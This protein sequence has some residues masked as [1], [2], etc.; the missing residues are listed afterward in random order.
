MGGSSSTTG[1]SRGTSLYDAGFTRSGVAAGS[2]AAKVHS[3]IGNVSKGSAFS[4]AQSRGA[5]GEG[6]SCRL[7]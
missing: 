6:G 5:K 4:N 7:F 3:K 1:G 2:T